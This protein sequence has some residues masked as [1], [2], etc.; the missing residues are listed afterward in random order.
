MRRLDFP[1]THGEVSGFGSGMYIA[2]H[3]LQKCARKSCWKCDYLESAL[4]LSGFF[5]FMSI[6]AQQFMM[7]GDPKKG[8]F[9]ETRSE[10]A[11]LSE[12]FRSKGL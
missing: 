9:I 1:D 5:P 7:K 12:T 10:F 11:L 8:S 3:C 6:T 4:S 2:R